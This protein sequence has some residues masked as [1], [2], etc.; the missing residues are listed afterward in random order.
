MSTRGTTGHPHPLLAV[1]FV[2]VLGSIGVIAA[3]F[4][5]EYR[6]FNLRHQQRMPDWLHRLQMNST[7]LLSIRICGFFALLMSGI[8]LYTFI[9]N[10]WR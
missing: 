2:L 9:A 3:F 10:F 6:D 8:V 1:V 5:R 4:P 7:T